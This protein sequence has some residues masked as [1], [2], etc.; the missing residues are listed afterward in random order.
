MYPFV[1]KTLLTK[2]YVPTVI[3]SPLSLN[4]FMYYYINKSVR[5]A[6]IITHEI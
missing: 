5:S 2:G 6:D 1:R 3:T 4:L